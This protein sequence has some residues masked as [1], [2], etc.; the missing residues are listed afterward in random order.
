MGMRDGACPEPLRF[1]LL[2]AASRRCNSPFDQ[3]L[4]TIPGVFECQCAGFQP[5]AM[6][7]IS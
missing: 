1:I 2:D 7:P 4:E 6:P 3:M 5:I